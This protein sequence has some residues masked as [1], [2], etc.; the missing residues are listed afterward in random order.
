MRK[1]LTVLLTTNFLFSSSVSLIS[2]N[3][4]KKKDVIDIS[5][6]KNTN[7]GELYVDTQNKLPSLDAIV[8]AMND[9]NINLN[10]KSRYVKI[11][12]TL[13]QNETTAKI[14]VI[15]LSSN[16]KGS[17]VVNYSIV[18]ANSEKIRLSSLIDVT[19]LQSITFTNDDSLKSLPSIDD[20]FLGMKAMNPKTMEIKR[21][22]IRKGFF[23]T[24]QISF[25]I[26]AFGEK[27]TGSTVFNFKKLDS[28]KVSIAKAFT[29]NNLGEMSFI[30]SLPSK[31][32]FLKAF[33]EKNSSS[34]DFSIN[35]F[36]FYEK[37]SDSET[38]EIIG[39]NKYSNLS[40]ARFSY[41]KK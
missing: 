41:I 17:V 6:I 3:I 5:L 22:E 14:T 29:N 39:N 11:D 7:L 32:V 37:G 25:C 38:I 10:L 24:T 4:D 40:H 26:E 18:K 30:E 13:T 36:E 19:D 1:I 9:K 34:S 23:G 16:F 12:D 2:C 31:E 28:S 27:Y 35:D 33:K 8:S 20:V 21:S 15:D